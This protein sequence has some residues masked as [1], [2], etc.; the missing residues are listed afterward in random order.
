LPNK[1][2]DTKGK[3]HPASALP[4]RCVSSTEC[5]SL[6]NLVGDEH[7]I[8]AKYSSPS[9]E[10][11]SAQE[12]RYLNVIVH[13]PSPMMI[14][15]MLALIGAFVPRDGKTRVQRTADATP[16]QNLMATPTGFGR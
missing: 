15:C 10:P 12:L 16:I 9:Q 6:A 4:V 1:R 3:I 7:M 13:P 5:G 8:K 11:H 14:T 2:A